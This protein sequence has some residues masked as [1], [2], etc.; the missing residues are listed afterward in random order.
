MTRPRLGLKLTGDDAKEFWENEKNPQVTEEQIELFK[1]ARRIYKEH[2]FWGGMTTNDSNI[3]ND[4][5]TIYLT[6]D[7]GHDLKSFCCGN[8][9]IDDFLK[10]CAIIDQ[11]DKLSRTYLVFLRDDMIGFFSLAA[12]SIEILAIDTTNGIEKFS[13][14][15]YPA[16]DIS[17][18]AVA[19]KFQGRGIGEY[20]LKVA[21]GKILSVS[22]DIGCRYVILDSVKDKVGFY[23]KYGFKIVDIYRNDEYKKMYLNM[24]HIE[25]AKKKL[26]IWLD[27]VHKNCT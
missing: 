21:I 23:K 15:V 3:I 6:R 19:K 7:R 8:D 14:S 10:N 1:E 4:I 17:K 18:L 22:E 20:I 24:V 9:D 13:E 12:S 11:E 25:S 26:K 2:P 16:I 27:T 5:R